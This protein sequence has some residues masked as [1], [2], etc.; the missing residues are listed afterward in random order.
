MP[1]SSNARIRRTSS[2]TGGAWPGDGSD[3][4]RIQRIEVSFPP[5]AEC[6]ARVRHLAAGILYRNGLTDPDLLDTV[7][8]L[9]SE[10][11]TNAITHGGGG[12]VSF[13]LECDPPREIRIEVDDHGR[14]T[15]TVRHPGPEAESGRGMALVE[16]LARSWGRKGSCTWC[17]VP[18]QEVAV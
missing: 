6:V 1:A 12:E 15:P 5:Q 2:A 7:Q 11:V 10:I 16:L 13:A 8:L 4:A 17:T 9:V 18:T 3:S 14:G